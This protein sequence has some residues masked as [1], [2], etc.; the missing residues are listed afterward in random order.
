M[1]LLLLLLLLLTALRDG[2]SARLVPCSSKY[3]CA[4]DPVASAWLDKVAFRY[5][6]HEA[7]QRY[8]SA[9][10]LPLLLLHELTLLELLLLPL[11]SL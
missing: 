1:L 9:R 7:A 2:E 3:V 6:C 11:S 5:G 4:A 10:T 8:G